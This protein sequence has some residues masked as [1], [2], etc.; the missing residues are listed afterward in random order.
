MREN[1]FTQQVTDAVE[2]HGEGQDIKSPRKSELIDRQVKGPHD[3]DRK[4]TDQGKRHDG[5]P[6]TPAPPITV[7]VSTEP[8]L[9]TRRKN[10]RKSISVTKRHGRNQSAAFCG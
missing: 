1:E 2:Q 9:L 5:N 8:A 4:E 10:P 7:F 6:I 3:D